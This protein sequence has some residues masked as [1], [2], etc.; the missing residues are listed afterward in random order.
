MQFRACG[1]QPLTEA[2]AAFTHLEHDHPLGKAVLPSPSR[3][4]SEPVPVLVS[5]EGLS[6]LLGEGDRDTG[7]R[8][9]LD[10]YADEI[11]PDNVGY[12]IVGP[13]VVAWPFRAACRR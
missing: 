13:A 2:R 12:V 3:H 10:A 6:S 4:W 8:R 11:D 7:V 1:S 5:P 9:L